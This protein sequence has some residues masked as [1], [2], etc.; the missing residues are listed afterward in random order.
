MGFDAPY[1][2]PGTYYD[3]FTL[4]DTQP[5]SG[6]VAPTPSPG[7]YEVYDPDY[8]PASFVYGTM[9]EKF[10]WFL[11]ILDG[12]WTLRGTLRW[13]NQKIEKFERPIRQADASYLAVGDGTDST[14]GGG[15]VVTYTKTLVCNTDLDGS[16]VTLTTASAIPPQSALGIDSPDPIIDDWP[17]T[18]T[19]T[20]VLPYHLQGVGWPT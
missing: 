3:D 12:S 18:V 15:Q 14:P 2:L 1:G 6:F 20:P 13:S 9:V 10:I 17:T 19:I 4:L 16:P 8:N 5:S 7:G 11:F